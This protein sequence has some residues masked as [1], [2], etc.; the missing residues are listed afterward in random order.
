MPLTAG[1]PLRTVAGTMDELADRSTPT[2]TPGSGSWSTSWPGPAWP[3]RSATCFGDRGGRRADRGPR[4][5][6]P[7]VG[8]DRSAVGARRPRSC[9]PSYPGRAR[10]RRR[11]LLALFAELL[12]ELAPGRRGR[13]AAQRRDA[14]LR[15][16]PRARPTV[17]FADADLFALV[18]STG[19][20]KSTVIDAVTFALYGSVARYDD[21]ASWHRS[22]T[23]ARLEAKGRSTSSWPARTTPRSGSC[24]H[25]ER[26]HHQ[27][28]PTRARR[29]PRVRRCWPARPTR[30]RRRRGPVGAGPSST[31]PR[32]SSCFPGRVRPLPP[33][34][35]ERS[36]E[37][38]PGA[39]RP[40][41]LRPDARPGPPSEATADGSRSELE[42]RLGATRE[43]ADPDA[44]AS[45]DAAIAVLDEL[46]ERIDLDQAR[47]DELQEVIDTLDAAVESARLPTSSAW[48]AVRRPG[49]AGREPDAVVSLGD[50]LDRRPRRRMT[51]PPCL[52]STRPQRPASM[53]SAGGAGGRRQGPC[54]PR[55]GTHRQS[56]PVWQLTIEKVA[57]VETA[58]LE[59]DAA[60][61]EVVE[62]E[63]LRDRAQRAALVAEICTARR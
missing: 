37:A 27:G 38:P 8:V 9:S 4:P 32:P 39:A 58:R 23:R 28:G 19:S 44:V 60:D 50:E 12:D 35:A 15:R 29:H 57:A 26:G 47:L 43:L 56:A 36:S 51:R 42:H 33:R 21:A 59:A 18:G 41:C 25:Q 49:D 10:R 55:P 2:A 48:T 14:G 63:A 53:P 31:S 54:R 3:T 17:D 34:Q 62:A 61:A 46:V 20:G 24:G 16:L 22:S 1:R 45:L 5:G 13:E 40:R 7:G 11:R 30:S 6:D 52:C